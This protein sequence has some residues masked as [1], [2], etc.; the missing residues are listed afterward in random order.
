LLPCFQFALH[1]INII[2]PLLD[3]I[4]TLTLDLDPKLSSK[5]QNKLKALARQD[6]DLGRIGG[7]EEDVHDE[8]FN[9]TLYP[10]PY[11]LKNLLMKRRSREINLNQASIYLEDHKGTS[12]VL[13]QGW[14]KLMEGIEKRGRTIM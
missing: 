13:G 5:L 8:S 14:N 2:N 7:G 12:P 10:K 9:F 3:S 1:T 4:G 11:L 6:E